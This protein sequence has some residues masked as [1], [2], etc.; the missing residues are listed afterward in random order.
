MDSE[1]RC[2][3]CPI[4]HGGGRFGFS[5]PPDDILSQY[6]RIARYRAGEI[7]VSQEDAVDGWGVVRSGRA[8]IFLMDENGRKHLVR[9]VGPGDLL[10]TCALKGLGTYCYSARALDRQVEAC[11]LPLPAIPVVLAHCPG[12]TQNILAELAQDLARSY[13]KL[14]RMATKSARARLAHQLLE[15]VEHHPGGG[16][17]STLP[18]P[19]QQLADTIGVSLET[20]VRALTQLKEGGWV[21]TRGRDIIIL[22]QDGLQSVAESE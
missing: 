17:N 21:D 1:H 22:D 10:G 16:K 13:R 18:V 15:L 14:H 3:D 6:S 12:I 11:W 9:V 7:I 19:R 4:A 5:P 20:A 2:S 8:E